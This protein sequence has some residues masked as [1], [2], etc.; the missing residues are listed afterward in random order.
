MS[1]EVRR[2]RVIFEAEDKSASTTVARMNA[3]VAAV[4][5]SASGVGTAAKEATKQVDLIA[6]AV[7]EVSAAHTKQA[8]K[9]AHEIALLR[10]AGGA[11]AQ[12]SKLVREEINLRAKSAQVLGQTVQQAKLLQRA[13]VEAVRAAATER[14][15]SERTVGDAQRAAAAANK[16]ALQQQADAQRTAD[17]A[18]KDALRSQVQ[19]LEQQARL[20]A[21]QR[22]IMAAI[23]SAAAKISEIRQRELG[24]LK[25]AAELQGKKG[26]AQA[27]G[28]Q[29]KVEAT[30]LRASPFGPANS[31]AG[32]GKGAGDSFAGADKN[33]SAFFA[34]LSKGAGPAATIARSLRDMGLAAFGIG[35]LTGALGAAVQAVDQLA[36]DSLAAQRA[37]YNLQFSIEGASA[38]FGGYVDNVSL[39]KAANKAYALGVAQTSGEF[40]TLA[41][42][43]N[44]L[45]IKLGEDQTQLLDNAITAIGRQ[46]ALILDN[47]GI[48]L[49]QAK[50]QQIFAASIGKTVDQ[51]DAYEKSISFAKA[52]TI[53][54]GEAGDDAGIA[55]GGMAAEFAQAKVQLENYRQGVLGFDESIGKTREAIRGLTDEELRRLEFGN[56]TDEHSRI[57]KEL[58]GYLKEWAVS[59]DDIDRLHQKLGISYEELIAQEK[60]RRAAENS[61]VERKRFEENKKA[62]LDGWSKE[63]D[64]IEHEIELRKILGVKEKD[65]IG[66]QTQQLKLRLNAAEAAGDLVEALSIQRQLEKAILT[67]E[68]KKAKSGGGSGPTQA[69]RIRAAGEAR[70]QVMQ[71]ELEQLEQAG[72]LL[73]VLDQRAVALGEKRLELQL[74]ELAVEREALLATKTKNAVERQ[75]LDTQLAANLAA[76]QAA[77]NSAVLEARA[78][79]VELIAKATR[80]INAKVAAERNE[81][82]RILDMSTFRLKAAGDQIKAEEAIALRGAKTDTQRFEITNRAATASHQNR[83]AQIKAER[84]ANLRELDIRE[85]LLRQQSG[86]DDEQKI[87]RADELKQTAHDREMLRMQAD[88]DLRRLVGEEQ[89]RLAASAEA[90]LQRQLGLV[91]TS[92]G[93]I[94]QAHG[95]LM[96]KVS[97][98]Q[99]RRSAADSADFEAWKVQQEARGDAQVNALDRELDAAKGNAAAVAKINRNKAAIQ[100][101]TQRQIAKAQ[102]A[103]DKKIEREQQRS[104]GTQLLVQGAV[105]TVR[106]AASY[107]NIPAMIAHFAA[108]ALAFTYGGMLVS[109]Q[110]PSAKA[111]AGASAGSGAGG[112]MGSAPSIDR[113]TSEAAKVPDSVPGKAAGANRFRSRSST[114]EQQGGMV[115]NINGDINSLGSIDNAA[116]EKIGIAAG[117]AAYQREGAA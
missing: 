17:K 30:Q 82:A 110:V 8:D 63:A 13:E 76:E 45:A 55:I 38:A 46:S 3:G 108:A 115:I 10:A 35:A 61:K 12:I 68:T 103:H 88:L 51:L 27:L 42:G 41:R 39:A 58:N 80:E 79:E 81:Q 102:V 9:I 60:R 92:I 75:R 87:A 107:P 83:I 32:A 85:E 84:D 15:A 50:G 5:K 100:R 24:L 64:A 52:A 90:T 77:R 98:F 94:E 99:G 19:Q 112:S 40:E 28:T 25:Q 18:R 71:A 6:K 48:V 91:N 66:L 23:G 47:L 7:G 78:A 114:G 70:T 95:E 14:K 49:T 37:S 105:S 69:D 113:S 22:Q 11:T 116:A 86:L 31:A 97:D 43:V 74:A 93:M 21:E 59:L 16:T 53:L 104:E 26:Q 89:A 33:A 36:T 111:G 20:L 62:R 65:L 117:K 109:G 96:S 2:A 106:G 54:I 34:T 67:A 72:E 1:D 4:G 101:N 73:G 29:A 57:G 44:V 56:F